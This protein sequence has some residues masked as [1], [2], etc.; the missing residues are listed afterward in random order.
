MQRSTSV[1]IWRLTAVQPSMCIRWAAWSD[2]VLTIMLHSLLQ[3]QSRNPELL[4]AHTWYGQCTHTPRLAHCRSP[5]LVTIQM[6]HGCIRPL[7]YRR[8]LKHSD[9]LHQDLYR[10]QPSPFDEALRH[11]E[12]CSFRNTG[13]SVCVVPSV[14]PYLIPFK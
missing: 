13:F 5:P 9:A 8:T 7:P 3:C 10:P 4:H 14:C 6:L 11:Q 1:T 12:N 2:Y